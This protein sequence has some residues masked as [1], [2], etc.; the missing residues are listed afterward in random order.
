VGGGGGGCGGGGGGGGWM[1]VCGLWVNTDGWPIRH[2]MST[3]ALELNRSLASSNHQPKPNQSKPK[4][5]PS[6]AKAAPLLTD[7][8]PDCRTHLYKLSV[9][10]RCTAPSRAP[11]SSDRSAAL[12][13]P[14]SSPVNQGSEY[15]YIGSR[16]ARSALER[17][18]FDVFAGGWGRGAWGFEGWAIVCQSTAFPARAAL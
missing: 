1:D 3:R 7:P 10:H 9:K 8:Q 5:S 12:A 11:T 16:V 15:W 6:Q 18:T 2:Q 4:P 14:S 17:V 13:A